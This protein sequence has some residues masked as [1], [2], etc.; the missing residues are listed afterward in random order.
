MHL[1]VSLFFFYQILTGGQVLYVCTHPV[2]LLAFLEIRQKV[3]LK[4]NLFKVYI[5]QHIG[6]GNHLL[7]NTFL[8]YHKYDS[9]AYGAFLFDPLVPHWQATGRHSCVEDRDTVNVKKA[10]PCEVPSSG[11]F[12]FALFPLDSVFCAILSY[13]NSPFSAVCSRRFT[14]TASG[15]FLFSLILIQLKIATHQGIIVKNVY[16]H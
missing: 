9:H 1:P 7:K 5:P 4:V 2:N 13:T 3:L 10:L 11:K 15:L 16:P 12:I 14:A 8:D 6:T